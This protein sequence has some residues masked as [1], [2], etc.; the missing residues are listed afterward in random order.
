MSNFIYLLGATSGIWFTAMSRGIDSPFGFIGRNT[1]FNL[2]DMFFLWKLVEP[3]TQ[4]EELVGGEGARAALVCWSR[5]RHTAFGGYINKV[6]AAFLLGIIRVI[7]CD[8]STAPDTN[9][10]MVE[11]TLQELRRCDLEAE[12]V[13]GQLDDVLPET[14][15]RHTEPNAGNSIESLHLL[16]STTIMAVNAACLIESSGRRLRNFEILIASTVPRPDIIV[17]HE[18]NGYS[19]RL[20]V[21]A[22]LLRGALR[23][24]ACEFSQKPL[25]DGGKHKAG[26]GIAILYKK[27]KFKAS[28]V[29]MT[30]DDEEVRMLDGHLGT[31]SLWRKELPHVPPLIVTVLYVPPK[32]SYKA[33]Y[34]RQLRSA[35]FKATLAMVD[36]IKIARKGSQHVIVAHANAADGLMDI[37]S[38]L[39]KSLSAQ[40]QAGIPI[41]PMPGL[42]MHLYEKQWQDSPSTCPD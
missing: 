13:G 32:A 9:P 40:Q 36:K 4:P 29:S 34:I 30:G 26:G 12:F 39:S 6:F 17:V 18:L 5:K 16:D 38:N 1:Y 37:G 20:N 23:S 27:L 41:V 35:A 8:N 3:A 33:A 10:V 24:Y 19:G 2:F 22:L 25:V 11:E 42:G 21:R 28:V 7:C 31:F 14:A 15:P